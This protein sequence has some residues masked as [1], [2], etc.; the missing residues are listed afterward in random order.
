MLK[1][2][3]FM[4]VIAYLKFNNIWKYNVT[5]FE[6]LY[7]M[8]IIIIIPPLLSNSNC[9]VKVINLLFYI[10]TRFDNCHCKLHELYSL[11]DIDE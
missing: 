6:H 2:E 10:L 8:I 5:S 1:L 9:H 11:I 7:F 4:D 3:T